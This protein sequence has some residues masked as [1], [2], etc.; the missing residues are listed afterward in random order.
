MR[1]SV[2]YQDDPDR[3]DVVLVEV[4]VRWLE[5]AEGVQQRYFRVLPRQEPM[6]QRVARFLQDNGLSREVGR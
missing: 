6:G 5:Q 4:A 1:F 2:Q 3:P